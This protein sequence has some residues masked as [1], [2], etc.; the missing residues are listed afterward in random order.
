MGFT[1]SY[2]STRP[3]T[4][5]EKAAIQLAARDTSKGRTWLG[6]EPV[7]FVSDED[8]YLVGSSKPNFV[9]HPDDVAAAAQDERPNGATRDMIDVLCQLSRDHA[10]DWEISHDFSNGPIGHI[11]SG[12]CDEEV[13]AQIE[14]FSELPD[15]LGEF[16]ID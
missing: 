14:I 16:G 5:T 3:V 15:I 6:C 7:H 12:T 13:L 11:K 10:V 1:V 8:R 2:R 9:P 4:P